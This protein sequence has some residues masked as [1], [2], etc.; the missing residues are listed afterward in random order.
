[1]LNALLSPRGGLSG[2]LKGKLS[3]N[4]KEL[5]EAFKYDIHS[6]YCLH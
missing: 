5:V 6:K 1:M 2:E 4:P 3:V